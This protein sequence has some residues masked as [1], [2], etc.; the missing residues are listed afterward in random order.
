MSEICE[1]NMSNVTHILGVSGISEKKKNSPGAQV[2]VLKNVELL[3]HAQINEVLN[4]P[5]IR[6]KYVKCNTCPGSV[7]NI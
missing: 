3:E 7:Q 5:N 4:V 1:I 6:N 2:N